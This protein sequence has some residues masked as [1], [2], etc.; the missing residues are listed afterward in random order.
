MKT[1]IK[2][3]VLLLAILTISYGAA[4]QL[5]VDSKD[6]TKDTDVQY[7]QFMYYLDQKTFRP[8]YMI[9]YGV[10]ESANTPVKRQKIQ[11][12]NEEIKDT[13]SPALVMNKLDKAGWEYLG[14]ATYIPVPLM[15]NLLTY[16]FRRKSRK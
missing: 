4:A 15:E 10:I 3:A 11:I 8:V 12:G 13:M 2:P 7:I 1:Y 14:D 5:I 16:T 6:V 9:D